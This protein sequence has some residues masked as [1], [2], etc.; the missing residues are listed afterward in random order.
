MIH[1]I[2]GGFGEETVRVSTEKSPTIRTLAG[3]GHIPS[4][5]LSEKALEYMDREV[6][7]GR[8]HWDFGH[9]SDVRNDKSATIVA[10]FFKGVP[11]NVFKDWGCVRKLT[12]VEC[13]KLQTL[14]VNYTEGISNTQRY[15]CIGN[16]WTVDVIAWIFGFIEKENYND[17]FD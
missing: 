16:G 10:N 8:N 14:P 15:R 17:R 9:F 6:R 5:I 2:Y 7:D 11:Y 3:E 13:E 1:N 12:P 4:L